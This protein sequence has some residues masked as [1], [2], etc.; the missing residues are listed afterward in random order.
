MSWLIYIGEYQN[1]L[2]SKYHRIDVYKKVRNTLF[3]EIIEGYYGEDVQFSDSPLLGYVRKYP[4]PVEDEEY[5]KYIYSMTHIDEEE[6]KK[7][8]KT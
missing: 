1:I 8:R 5:V 2:L 6:W 4:K 3:G 7:L